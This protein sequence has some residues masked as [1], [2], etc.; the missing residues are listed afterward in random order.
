MA[1]S[2]QSKLPIKP[3]QILEIIIRRRWFIIIPLCI[4]LTL[5]L[6]ITFTMD[7]TYEASTLILVQPQRVPSDYIKSVVTSSISQRISTIS[8]Q[9]LSRSNLEKIIHQFGLFEDAKNMYLEDK[10]ASMRERVLVKI[11]R[12]RH[13]TEAFSIVFRGSDPQRVMG[14]ANTLAGYF[15][16]ENLKFR[17]AQAVGTSDFLDAELQKTRKRLEIREKILADY[18][19]KYL[20]GL[21]DE[22]ETNL[23]T[24]D[25]LQ[26]QLTS[27][28]ELL[29]NTSDS[30]NIL[31][32]QIAQS[33][34]M[35]S[36]NFDNQFSSFDFDEEAF[37]GTENEQK[38]SLAKEQ[39]NTLL[40]KY[41][42]KHPDVAKLKKIIEKLEKTIEEETLEGNPEG[43]TEFSEQG[44]DD[45]NQGIG[46]PDFAAI[47]QEAQVKQIKNEIRKI[48]SD[49]FKI[50]QQMEIYQKRVEDTPK[51]ELELQSLQR[52]YANIQNV[53]N[54][55]LDRRLEA[56]LSVN[57]EK[58]QKGEQ[59]RIIDHARL[60]EK[61]ISPNVK[62]LFLLSLASGFG[63]G[64]GGIYLL[65]MFNTSIRREEQ[66]EKN[67]GLTILAIIP[68]LKKKGHQVKAKVEM[69]AF[70][71]F[72]IYATAFL[73]FFVILN[74]KG[75]DRTIYF[76]K[77]NLNF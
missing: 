16:D 57:M 68:H 14:I 60:P 8:Q 12:A 55:L 5:G 21:P 26:D 69:V 24:L 20:G 37:K 39:Y 47:Q 46:I 51:R 64:G 32:T 22:L 18:R 29:R 7:K 6:F 25:R 49:I 33:K 58:K 15:M 56:E 48:Q 67:L 1:D 45:K 73:S 42:E 40:L 41:T 72:T 19:T 71:C 75:L 76:I 59:F 30:L 77:S 43:E 10:I 13:G 63:L 4:T 50:E 38:Y 65:E 28:Q 2:F 34:E 62:L 66:I 61:P 31:E 9:I 36:Q 70:V 74:S 23:R 54:S 11:E 52:D 53:F 44:V 3:D 35:A 17:E 27:K